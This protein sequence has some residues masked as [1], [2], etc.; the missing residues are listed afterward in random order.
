M[1]PGLSAFA[2]VTFKPANVDR[3]YPLVIQNSTNQD[4]LVRL[5]I[6][7]GNAQFN[8]PGPN[9]TPDVEAD[10]AIGAFSSVTGSAVVRAGQTNPVVIR[11]KQIGSGIYPVTQVTDGLQTS[12]T[13]NTAGEA[14]PTPSST[15]TRDPAIAPQPFVTKPF[16]TQFPRT[17]TSEIPDLTT[18]PPLGQNPP[19]LGA[20]SAAARAESAAARPEP[21]AACPE[22]VQPKRGALWNDDLRQHGSRIHGNECRQPLGGLLR[23]RD[24]AESGD[25]TKWSVGLHHSGQSHLCRTMAGRLFSV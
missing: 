19:P 10:I 18:P 5:T 8:T 14:D 24:A 11:I 3:D 22:H 1:T 20:E 16:G 6:S 12:V 15:E 13:I 2:P 4:M 23:N 7:T 17:I 9:V 25:S 21:A